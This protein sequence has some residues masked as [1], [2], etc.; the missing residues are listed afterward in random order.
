MSKQME[1]SGA[2]SIDEKLFQAWREEQ[3]FF[4]LRGLAR[5]L[6]WV[7]VMVLVDFVIDWQIFFRSRWE[8]PGVLLL[9][10]NVAVLIWVLQ[11]EWLRHLKPFDSLRVALEVEN[12]HP[13]LRSVLV[14]FTQLQD[15]DTEKEKASPALLEAMRKQAISL[16][17]PLDFREV[18]DFGQLKK[19]VLVSLASIGVFLAIS[20]E[21]KEH[22]Q[23]L[24]KRLLGE[25]L[26]YPTATTILSVESEKTIKAGSPVE[27]IVKVKGE[28][29]KKGIL[30]VRSK[31][32]EDWQ[33][34]EMPGGTT[35]SFVREIPEVFETLDYYVKIG[36]DVSEEFTVAVSPTPEITNARISLTYPDY[37]DRNDSSEEALNFAVPEGTR[38]KWTLQCHPPIRALEVTLGEEKLDANVSENGKEA[39]FE[40]VAEDTFKYTFHWTEKDHG[41]EYPDIQ[42]LVRVIPDRIPDVE[43]VEPSSNGVATVEKVLQLVARATDDHQLGEA[44]LLYSINGSEEKRISMEKLSGTQ[45]DIRYRWPLNEKLGEEEKLKPGD[46]VTFLIEVSDRMPPLGSHINLSATRRLTIMSK[47]QYLAWFKSE[48][49]AQR[50]II[51]KA[52]DSEKRATTEVSKLK[53][54]EKKE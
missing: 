36:D 20:F 49:D 17:R 50:E 52:R 34:L 39:V 30:F 23:L 9:I 44:T 27:V 7:V 24:F 31:N 32:D 54:E 10:V 40:A 4:H 46:K 19:L 26:E 1:E 28:I 22:M 41:F 18:V 29:P 13:E 3:R 37:L 2:S 25:N 12:K 8:T 5:F 6:I 42:R 14:S 43:L 35:N 33:P 51:V 11:R 21:W 38:I 47:E 48:L 53:V 16:T 45:K 15:F